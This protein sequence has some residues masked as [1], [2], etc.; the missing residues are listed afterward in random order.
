MLVVGIL[1]LMLGLPL[2]LVGGASGWTLYSWNGKQVLLELHDG[3]LNVCVADR[4]TFQGTGFAAKALS[5]GSSWRMNVGREYATQRGG[6][7]GWVVSSFGGPH[8]SGAYLRIVNVAVMPISFFLLLVGS[9]V[10]AIGDSHRRRAIHKHCA[11]CNYDLAG[12]SPNAPC[13]ECGRA[14]PTSSPNNLT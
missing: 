9:I 4:P 5:G 6:W 7:S 10:T 14:A 12:L 3:L 2:F 11:A 1:M 13:P 8:N